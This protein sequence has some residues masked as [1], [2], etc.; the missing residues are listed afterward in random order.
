MP[1]P[2][3]SPLAANPKQR[4]QLPVHETMPPEL[5]TMAPVKTISVQPPVSF[6]TDQLSKGEAVEFR[7]SGRAGQFLKVNTA[8]PF[9]VSVQP[10]D[11]PEPLQQG[12]DNADNW[13]Y[14]LPQT[15]TYRIKFAPVKSPAI[16]FSFLADNDPITDAGIRRNQVSIDFGSF[17]KG[18][19]LEVA[20]YELNDGVDYP[21]SW[22]THL[23]LVRDDF[24]F[25]IMT[26]EGYKKIFSEDHSNM[27]AFEKALLK[28]GAG[29]ESDKLPY[30][31]FYDAGIMMWS[32]SQVL[33]G[34]GWHGLRWIVDMG[35][36]YGCELYLFYLFEGLS[37]DGRYFIMLKSKIS[38]APV[39]RQFSKQCEDASR[40][41]GNPGD[42][43]YRRL[44]QKEMTG[45][46]P[47]SFRPNLNQLDGVL[48]SLKLQ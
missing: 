3:A 19:K 11:G 8:E 20:P 41:G 1:T 40:P 6:G 12:G 25:R 27:D 24:S 16:Q 48:R 7:L 29:L 28:G 5:K 14:A 23:A 39:E 42:E 32:R 37:D 21:D 17:A 15:G 31:A 26:V 36:D 43:M 4:I 22:P 9:R 13:F 33:R 46:A 30:S 38:N 10:P 35:Q 2:F 44:F 34:P 47:D 18:Q 45:A